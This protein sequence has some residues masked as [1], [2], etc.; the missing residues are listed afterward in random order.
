MPKRNPIPVGTRFSRLQTV[1]TGE[2]RRDSKGRPHYVC[3]CRC[4]CGTSL[5][6]REQCLRSGNTRSCGCLQIESAQVLKFKHGE[7][8]SR[9]YSIWMNMH[10]RCTSRH[11]SKWKWYGAKGVMVCARWRDYRLFLKD[12]GECPTGKSIDRWPNKDGNYEPGNCRWAT[13]SEQMRNTSS[14]RV[15]TFGGFTGPLVEVCERFGLPYKALVDRTYK[16]QT[17]EEAIA[18]IRLRRDQ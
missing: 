16:G 6:I 8:Q 13:R 7:C 15:I 3:P 17:P 18:A 9:T 4:D 2:Q 12:M 10:Q 14:N 11:S 5:L 1:G